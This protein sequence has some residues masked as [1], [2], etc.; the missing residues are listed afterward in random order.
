MNILL[1]IDIITQGYIYMIKIHLSK[2]LGEKRISQADL[3][4]R[5]GIRPNSINALYHEYVKYISKDDL[6]KICE[7]LSCS[8]TDLIEYIPNNK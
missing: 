2:L 6:D 7:A 4:R 8:V 5:T 3:S 1:I